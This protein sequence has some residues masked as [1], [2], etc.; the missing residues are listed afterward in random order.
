MIYDV[1]KYVLTFFRFT[2]QTISIMDRGIDMR[3]SLASHKGYAHNDHGASRWHDITEF[4]NV[5][6]EIVASIPQQLKKSQQSSQ[7]L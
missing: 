6:G 1:L 2:S 7:V 5:A 4:E 3:R